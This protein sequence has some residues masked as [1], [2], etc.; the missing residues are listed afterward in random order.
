MDDVHHPNRRLAQRPG[1]PVEIEFAVTG[2]RGE[3]D[4]CAGDLGNDL[5]GHDPAVV[6]H[7]GHQDHVA[8]AE[9]ADPPRPGNQVDRLGGVLGEDGALAWRL[10]Q[11]CDRIAAGL[12]ARGGLFGQ[13]VHPAVDIRV[14]L[15]VV[16]AHGVEYGGGLLGRGRRIEVDEGLAVPDRGKDREVRTQRPRVDIC[17]QRHRVDYALGATAGSGEP[18]WAYPP[19]SSSSAS[20]GPPVRTTLPSNIT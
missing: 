5:P 18:Y 14:S 10:D 4:S 12:E 11:P 15:D 2:D 20:S 3:H 6:L 19:A 9:V 7:L 17:G 8:W 13:R 16:P 1:D